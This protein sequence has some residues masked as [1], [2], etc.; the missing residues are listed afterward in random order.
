MPWRLA[1][2]AVRCDGTAPVC[3]KMALVKIQQKVDSGKNIHC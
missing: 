2:K 1:V 3:V